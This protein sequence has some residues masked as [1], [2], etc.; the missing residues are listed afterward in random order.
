MP[1]RSKPDALL[2][3]QALASL[4][5]QERV[6]LFCLASD[7]D[8]ER[9][10]VTHRDGVAS[11]RAGLIDRTSTHARFKLTPPGRGVR[12]VGEV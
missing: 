11:A 2:T 8:S 3:P 4:S 12:A 6:L 10:G 9:A 5:V 1:V 7:A